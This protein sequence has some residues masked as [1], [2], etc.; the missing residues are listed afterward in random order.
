MWYN[1]YVDKEEMSPLIEERKMNM[2]KRLYLVVDVE[3]ANFTDDPFVY[4]FGMAV[5]DKDGKVYY[6]KSVVVKDIFYREK[7]LMESAYY[8]VK[9][10]EYHEAIKRGISQVMSFY[11]LRRLVHSVM[12]RYNIYAV[13]AYNAYF[14]TTAS[15]K[16]Q[17]W[18]TKSK[19][20]FFFPYGTKVYCIWNMA[21]QTICN[22]KN[23]YKFC[24]QNGLV[25]EK[26]NISTSAESVYAYL[27]S[28]PDFKEEHKGL[29][30]VLIEAEIMAKCF[31]SH[32][33][34]ERGINRGCWRIAQKY[35]AVA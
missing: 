12:K 5:C 29:D 4:D 33:K 28:N 19:Y 30:D 7:E 32:K 34:M 26:G 1:R 22:K 11:E 13:C 27:H 16:T 35:N 6:K 23:Y 25:S 14:D 9:I 17:R 20:R 15:N 31:K 24:V 10:P 21:C 2:N 3:T 8:A 18:L